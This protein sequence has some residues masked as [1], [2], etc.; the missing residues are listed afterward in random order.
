MRVTI[1][2]DGRS[3]VVEVADDLTRATIG[4]RSFPVTV[5]A[6]SDTRVELE[7]AGEKVVVENWLDHFPDPPGPVDVNGERWPIRVVRGPGVAPV[8][9]REAPTSPAPAQPPASESAPG[10]GTGVPVV[11]PMPGKVIEV[12]VREWD[13][14]K[15]GDVLL[16]LEAMKMR[17][18]VT[19]PANGT[20]KDLRVA[21]GT[22]VRA[23]EPMLF[24]VPGD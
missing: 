9:R 15:K 20:V 10:T 3:T 11:P 22:N 14:V 23:R 17:N 18:E 8:A 5:V 24:V 16:V 19:S 13:R 2:R 1:E 6:R 12:R 21:A 7:V 4:G